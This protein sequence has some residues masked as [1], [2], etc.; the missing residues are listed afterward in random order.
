MGLGTEVSERER[1]RE[2]EERDWDVHKQ[3]LTTRMV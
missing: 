3:Q 1:E 2:K